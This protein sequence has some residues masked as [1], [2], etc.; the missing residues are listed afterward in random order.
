MKKKVLLAAIAASC[1]LAFTAP[2]FAAPVNTFS[3][4]PAKHWSYDAIQKLSKEGVIEGYSDGTFRGDRNM[5]RYEMAQIVA[6]VMTKVDK[7]DAKQKMIIDKLVQEYNADLIKI[8]A[9]LAK[10]EAKQNVSFFFDNRIQWN[11]TNLKPTSGGAAFG[12]IGANDQQDQ[13]MER[14]RVYMSGKV[15]DQWQWD[16]RLVQAKFNI[17]NNADSTARFD[18]FWVTGK[19]ILGGKVE[20]GKMWLYAGKGAFYGNTGDT[21]GLYYTRVFDKLSVR[22]G[23]GRVGGTA[24]TATVPSAT[25]GGQDVSFVEATYR[26]TKTMDIGVYTLKSDAGNGAIYKDMDLRVINGAME[27][28]N[29]GGL[30]LSFEYAQNRPK[31]SLLKKESGYFVALQSNYKSTNYMPALYTSLV[32]PFIKGDHGWG[33]SY[34]HLPTGVAGLA[35]RGAFSWVPL[36]TDA[37]GTWQNNYNGVNAWRFDYI[38]VPWKNVQL[39]ISYDRSKPIVGDWVNNSIQTTFNFFF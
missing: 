12:G 32:N 9:R 23:T 30:A 24:S 26:P 28:P 6:N 10:V 17:D 38:T 20:M 31:S 3:D 16:A 27:I 22:L 11:H 2:A 36:T 19:D 34:R 25:N 13:F 4:V 21:E 18:R 7:A 8:G 29:T 33:I 35:N 39:T 37:D 1:T 15:G 5:T 14:I